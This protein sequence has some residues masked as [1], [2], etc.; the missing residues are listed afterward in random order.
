M[1][2]G[3][4]N[5]TVTPQDMATVAQADPMVAE[6]LKTAALVRMLGEANARTADLEAQ[7]AKLN[8]TSDEPVP[9]KAKGK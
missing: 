6:K 5:I 1:A 4:V 9:E 2:E 3:I 8:G 7:V